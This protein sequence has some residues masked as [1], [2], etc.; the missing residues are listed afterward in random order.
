MP[1]MSRLLG[2]V[3]FAAIFGYASVIALD[4]F[5]DRSP[6]VL[7][8]EIN[9]AIASAIGWH[10]VGRLPGDRLSVGFANGITGAV[11]ISFLTLAA[12]G[13]V[14]MF[15]YT[16]DLKYDDLIE[17]VIGILESALDIGIMIQ[18]PEL[19]AVVFGGGAVAGILIQILHKRFG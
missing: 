19:T 17:A 8:L 18:S 10:M 9:I 16:R 11:V 4:A 15:K 12:H 14:Q 13:M 3:F 7:F 1:T 2:A 5:Q 6:P